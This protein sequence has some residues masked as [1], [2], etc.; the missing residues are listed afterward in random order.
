MDEK[1]A[2]LMDKWMN[3]HAA[4]YFI[5]NFIAEQINDLHNNILNTNGITTLH[6]GITADSI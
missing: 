6:G 2:K 4:S 3:R 1:M 5:I